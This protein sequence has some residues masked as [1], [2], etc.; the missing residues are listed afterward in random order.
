MGVQKR[1]MTV[2]AQTLSASC[3][4]AKSLL[5]AFTHS[6][7]QLRPAISIIRALCATLHRR[8]DTHLQRFHV[9][10]THS[11]LSKSSVV[12]QAFYD[13]VIS[14]KRHR[15]TGDN[16][17]CDSVLYHTAHDGNADPCDARRCNQ[18]CPCMERHD[19]CPAFHDRLLESHLR[20][21][22]GIAF[23]HVTSKWALMITSAAALPPLGTHGRDGPPRRT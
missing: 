15:A 22:Q 3:I 6:S 8:A 4:H 21:A 9:G 23:N 17:I 11:S 2:S 14:P 1:K 7:L 5:Y 16:A 20:L 18:G 10:G 19:A 12:L 13:P